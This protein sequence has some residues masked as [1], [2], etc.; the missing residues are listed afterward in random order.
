MAQFYKDTKYKILETT[1]RGRRLQRVTICETDDEIAHYQDVLKR[2]CKTDEGF[3]FVAAIFSKTMTADQVV[4]LQDSGERAGA[5]PYDKV[6]RLFHQS[7]KPAKGR[8]WKEDGDVYNWLDATTEKVLAEDTQKR[9]RRC[10]R[11]LSKLRPIAKLHELPGLLKHYREQCERRGVAVE[12][13]NT[14]AAC[15]SYVSKRHGGKHS[16]LWNEITGIPIIKHESDR[17]PRYVTPKNAFKIAAKLPEICRPA[18]WM[19]LLSGMRPISEYKKHKWTVKGNHI[20]MAKSKTPKRVIPLVLIEGHFESFPTELPC[21]HDWLSRRMADQG[22]TVQ[23]LRNSYIRY[24]ADLPIQ[25]HFAQHYSGHKTP[26]DM[27]TF[28]A[29]VVEEDEGTGIEQHAQE[30]AK[31]IYSG[32]PKSQQPQWITLLDPENMPQPNW[33]LPQTM[34]GK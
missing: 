11:N 24:L 12:F 10:F 19:I 22:Y 16:P 29:R 33:G 3:K 34:L 18:F 4:A 30:I 15:Q 26:K 5:T 8:K 23:D 25:H 7:S 31:R 9:Y 1:L 32:L 20:H 27:T 17:D 13:R 28:Y 2:L 6:V 21:S 14:K